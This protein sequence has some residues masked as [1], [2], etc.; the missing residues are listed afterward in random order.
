MHAEPVGG[1][2]GSGGGGGGGGGGGTASEGMLTFMDNAVDITTGTVLLQGTFPNTDGTLLPGEFVKVWLRLFR[3]RRHRRAGLGGRLGTAGQLRVRRAER[4]DRK[5]CRHGPAHIRQPSPCWRADQAGRSGGHRRAAP[6]TLG[7]QG[8]DQGLGRQ[9]G[10]GRGI[11]NI[12]GLFI[13]R[14]VMTTLVMAGILIFGFVAYRLLPVSDLPTVDYP[15]VSVSASL[16]GR[17]R[18]RWRPRWRRRSR[19]SSPRL[20]ASTR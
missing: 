12:T 3:T 4:F 5:G 2:A 16:P 6:P 11:M 17:A 20:P 19:S 14:P 1:T 7:I 18:R 9:R 15:T 10:A 13:R 8:T